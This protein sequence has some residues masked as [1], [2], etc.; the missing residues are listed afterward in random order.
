MNTA[1][2][3]TLRL[4]HSTLSIRNADDDC[5][6]DFRR[7]AE[8]IAIF[9]AVRGHNERLRTLIAVRDWCA[10][11]DLPPELFERMNNAIENRNPYPM[12]EFKP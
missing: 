5:V 11:G 3:D 9:D 7:K 10:G 8:A 4:N 6:A 12:Q 2:F 1:F